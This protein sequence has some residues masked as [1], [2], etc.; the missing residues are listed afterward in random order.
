PGICA[1]L[2]DKG[3]PAERVHHVAN[4]VGPPRG[5][6]VDRAAIGTPGTATLMVALGRLHRNKAFDTLLRAL[7]LVPGVHLWL[8]GSGPEEGALKA[9]AE[10]LK[11][12]DRVRF[13]GW[14]EDSAE[15]IA[16][17]DIFCCP[18]RHEP[19]GNVI[20]EAWAAGRPVIAAAASGPKLMVRQEEDGLLVPVDDVPAL[21]T[22]IAR[23]DADRLLAA[24][25]AAAGR[26]RYEAEFSEPSVV[27]QWL[28]FFTR[29]SGKEAAPCAA[30]PD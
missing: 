28:D 25:L 11:L 29:I 23:L 8:A 15:L 3:W 16:A 24:R 12:M 6:A 9:L 19:F 14:R 17:A 20:A 13:L 10:E 7:A 27:R 1:Y 5:P 21:A 26:V 2:R 30:S 18:S 4:F 22:A